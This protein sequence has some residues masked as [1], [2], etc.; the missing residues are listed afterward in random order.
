QPDVRLRDLCTRPYRMQQPP[1]VDSRAVRFVVVGSP[2]RRRRPPRCA[3]P[4]RPADGRAENDVREDVG[5]AAGRGRGAAGPT[6]DDSKRRLEFPGPLA[7]T[8]PAYMRSRVWSA[9]ATRFGET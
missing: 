4:A 1:V 2:G 5:G 8:L 6:T 3:L 9:C 7:R